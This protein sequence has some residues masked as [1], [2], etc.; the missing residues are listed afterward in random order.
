M[1]CKCAT[2][3]EHS[4]RQVAQ[5][6]SNERQKSISD[7][8][9]ILKLERDLAALSPDST[10]WELVDFL[11]SGSYFVAKVKFETCE[12]AGYGG[13]KVL[14]FKATTKEAILWRRMDPHFREAPK[15]GFNKNEAPVPIARFPASV[16]GWEDAKAFVRTKNSDTKNNG[17]RDG[18]TPHWR[19][20]EW[21]AE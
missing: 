18:N 20:S 14:V 11:E 8:E 1:V 3:A 17:I 15:Q 13:Q 12:H 9:K 6:L 10:K 4:A 16:E 7:K 2:P 21:K 5:A 19:D